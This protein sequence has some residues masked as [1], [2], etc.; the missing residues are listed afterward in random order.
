VTADIFEVILENSGIFLESGLVN[1]FFSRAGFRWEAE[2]GR[3]SIKIRFTGEF[4]R[5]SVDGAASVK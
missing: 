2:R 5:D 3:I 4:F 1:L